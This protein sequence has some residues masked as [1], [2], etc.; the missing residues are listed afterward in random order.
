ML[1]FM[2]P[3]PSLQTEPEAIGLLQKKEFTVLPKHVFS[4]LCSIIMLL[5]LISVV[6]CFI[7]Y[8]LNYNSR[9]QEILISLFY[10][11][12][13]YNIPTY[14]ASLLLLITSIVLAYIFI[15]NQLRNTSHRYYWAILS[16]IFLLMSMD[17]YMGLHERLIDPLRA[18]LDPGKWLYFTW[19]VPA[20]VAVL[21]TGLFFLRFFFN[22]RSRIRKMFFIA[23][24]LY[25]SGALG[26]EMLGGY[27][28]HVYGQRSLH[29]PMTVN[30]EEFMEM[31]AIAYFIYALLIYLQ[32]DLDQKIKI[33]FMEQNNTS[34]TPTL[35]KTEQ[36]PIEKHG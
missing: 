14:F 2:D 35:F 21:I 29:Y 20:A 34:N 18:Y 11:D 19:V 27:V 12:K 15:Q 4:S 8:G 17:E 28:T 25:I 9:I 7:S 33:T 5:V 6:I 36:N 26:V 31:F 3:H 23:G 30:L 10:L 32:T 22:L 16:F 13:E 1:Y 24:A